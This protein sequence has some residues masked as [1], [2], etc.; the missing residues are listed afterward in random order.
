LKSV[1][2]SPQ[3]LSQRAAD[4]APVSLRKCY[5]ATPRP[6]IASAGTMA[7]RASTRPRA[8]LSEPNRARKASDSRRRGTANPIQG[9]PQHFFAAEVTEAAN[10][11]QRGRRARAELSGPGVRVQRHSSGFVIAEA[12]DRLGRASPGGRDR[13]VCR[14]FHCVPRGAMGTALARRLAE[15]WQICKHI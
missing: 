12:G 8:E 14:Q 10:A 15:S 1:S 5:A 7:T 6:G 4:P 11:A 2:A 9:P 13:P 3:S